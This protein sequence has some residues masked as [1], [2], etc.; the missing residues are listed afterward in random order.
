LTTRI[1]RE[2][3]PHGGEQL[4]PFNFYRKRCSNSARF[5]RTKG[6][7]ESCSTACCRVPFAACPLFRMTAP[8]V[9]IRPDC[10]GSMRMSQSLTV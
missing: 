5:A 7:M 8:E 1:R 3:P 2:T 10:F 9:R 6:R 4:F